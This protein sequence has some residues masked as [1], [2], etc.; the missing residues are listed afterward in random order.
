[1]ILKEKLRGENATQLLSEEVIFQDL[2][3]LLQ[4]GLFRSKQNL[5][6]QEPFEESDPYKSKRQDKT[7]KDLVKSFPNQAANSFHLRLNS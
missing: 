6:H 5:Y 2:N 4:A 3:M 7:Q 1:M